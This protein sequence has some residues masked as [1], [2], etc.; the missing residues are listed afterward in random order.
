MKS[1]QGGI[2]L[3]SRDVDML[4]GPIV[5]SMIKFAIPLILT[6][7]LSTLYHTA[8]ILVVGNFAGK[9]ALAAVGATSSIIS[10]LVNVFVNIS[11]G[12][13]IILARALGAKDEKRTK[14]VIST[15][16]TFSLI[17][18]VFLA[19]FLVVMARP[20]LVLTDCPD[21]VM[22]GAL[23]YMRIYALGVPAMLFYNFM[24][25]VIRISGDSRRP[26][27]YMAISGAVNILLNLTLVILTGEAIISVA[28][29]TVVSV[30]TSALLLL[31]RLMRLDGAKKLIPWHFSIDKDDLFKIIRLGVPAAISG[32]TF[33][34]TSVLIQSAVNT[35]GDVGM[36][37]NTASATLEGFINPVSMS[38]VAVVTAFMGQNMGAGNR[39]R[40][41]KIRKCAYALFGLT[42]A[43]ISIVCYIFGRQLFSLIIP[44]EAEAIEFAMTRFFFVAMAMLMHGFLTVNNGSLQAFGYTMFQ[45]L[46]NLIGTCGFRIAWMWFIYPLNPTP[47]NLYSCFPVSYVLVLALGLAANFYL[48]KKYKKGETFEI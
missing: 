38:A 29:G 17:L 21:N 20:M 34:L 36:S 44:G 32:A 13:G 48:V 45:M 1:K 8:D 47:Q 39:E 37:G 18:G 11:V 14:S 25:G 26:F 28:V 19:L 3:F 5:P 6:N 10:L 24:S 43:V 22:G 16:Y 35:Y 41:L 7:I 40:V 2:K 27:I 30:Y 15:A 23:T 42:T 9:S 12:F 33:A 4:D 46:V 31:V